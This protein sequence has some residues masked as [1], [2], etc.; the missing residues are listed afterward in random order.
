MELLAYVQEIAVLS[1]ALFLTAV[2]TLRD[3]YLRPDIN[4]RWRQTVLYILLYTAMSIAL[5]VYLVLLQLLD[6]SLTF[7]GMV[8]IL[9]V[10]SVCTVCIYD[11][12]AWRT[13]LGWVIGCVIVAL[14]LLN[15]WPW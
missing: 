1:V 14:T 6:V 7:G 10:G 9:L 8:I 3:A 11:T 2:H 15:Y 4:Q 5:A 12:G 13:Q